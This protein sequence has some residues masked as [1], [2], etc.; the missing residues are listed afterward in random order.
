MWDK[1][2]T[3]FLVR[4]KEHIAWELK[5]HVSI[6]WNWLLCRYKLHR[7]EIRVVLL[8]F[9]S[10]WTTKKASLFSLECYVNRYSLGENKGLGGQIVKFFG[11]FNLCQARSKILRGACYLQMCKLIR[12]YCAAF[13]VYMFEASLYLHCNYV[14]KALKLF[15]W[16]FSSTLNG[17]FF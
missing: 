5:K 10:F 16:L 7:T 17:V 14:K 11:P 4:I 12:Y 13:D 1:A 2:S 15:W 8:Y 9:V 3:Y 6:F